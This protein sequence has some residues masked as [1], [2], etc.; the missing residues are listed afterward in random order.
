MRALLW[1]I[2]SSVF[3]TKLTPSFRVFRASA[4]TK[5]GGAPGSSG[6]ADDS[7][8]P[9]D[10]PAALYTAT[11]GHGPR[12]LDAIPSLYHPHKGLSQV[13][14]WLSDTSVQSNCTS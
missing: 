10:V 3:L 8:Y 7:T 2:D 1:V 12:E 9:V 4:P 13:P 14:Q 5:L 11:T 6:G